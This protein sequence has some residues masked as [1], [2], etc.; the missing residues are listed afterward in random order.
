MYV[1]STSATPA[2]MWAFRRLLFRPDR[3]VLPAIQLEASAIQPNDGWCDDTSDGPIRATIT[4]NGSHEAVDALLA[5]IQIPPQFSHS[6]RP[7]SP[8]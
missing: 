2:G 1:T 3:V 6:K 8:N 7:L 4:V 5:H